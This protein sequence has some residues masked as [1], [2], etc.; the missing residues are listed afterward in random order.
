M[1]YAEKLESIRLFTNPV[2]RRMTAEVS[3]NDLESW[4]KIRTF[5]SSKLL[6][7]GA[8]EKKKKNPIAADGSR[9]GCFFPLLLLLVTKE[10]R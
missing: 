2:L 7:I 3:N 6:E 10:M 4:S 1:N 9:D 5:D 8:G